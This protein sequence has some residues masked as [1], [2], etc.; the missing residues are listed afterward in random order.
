MT[1]VRRLGLPVVMQRKTIPDRRKKIYG[2]S[3]ERGKPLVRGRDNS[4]HGLMN[5]VKARINR[6]T[7]QLGS[8]RQDEKVLPVEK[9][10]LQR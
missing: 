8:N 2:T 6:F 9:I 1:G 4:T 10:L 5:G 3:E 7:N